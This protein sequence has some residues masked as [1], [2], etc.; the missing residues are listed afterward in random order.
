MQ[1]GTVS[2]RRGEFACGVPLL[3][4]P[5]PLHAPRANQAAAIPK[6]VMLMLMVGLIRTGKV[7]TPYFRQGKQRDLLPFTVPA[8]SGSDLC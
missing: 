1:L 3:L 5:S 4:V 2:W 7:V 8:T 6:L